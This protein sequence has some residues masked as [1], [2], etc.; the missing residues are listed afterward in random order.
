MWRRGAGRLETLAISVLK[1]PASQ[2]HRS[3]GQCCNR[4]LVPTSSSLI[5]SSAAPFAKTSPLF[6]EHQPG[7]GVSSSDDIAPLWQLLIACYALLD[8]CGSS[9]ASPVLPSV[10]LGFIIQHIFCDSSYIHLG[11]FILCIDASDGNVILG[12]WSVVHGSDVIS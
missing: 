6:A 10:M 4:V 3:G 5:H 8:M 7:D 11:Q 9:V 1:Q 12:L 2:H